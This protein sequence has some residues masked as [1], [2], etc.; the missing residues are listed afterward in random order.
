MDFQIPENLRLMVDTV[1]RFVKQDLEPISRQVEDEDRIRGR[2]QT[3][4][5]LGLFGLAIPRTTAR[6]E[7]GLLGECLVYEELSKANACFRTRIGTN[8]GI[9]AQGI[10]MEA[11]RN[12][13]SDT[14]PNY[15][16]GEWT[17]CFALSERKRL[18]RGQCPDYC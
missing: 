10:I 5:D 12:K 16:S 13:K 2:V 18:R 11:R 9:G 6:L 1:R 17:G 8:N 7:V 3:M 14:C 4:R 15:G